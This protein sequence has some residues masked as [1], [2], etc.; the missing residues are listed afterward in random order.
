M[1]KIS[2]RRK[3][4]LESGAADYA[5]KRQDIV[6]AAAALFKDV[7]LG[8]ATM[9][10]VAKRA[11][12]DRASLYYYFKGKRD[13][14]REMVGAAT[15][16]NIEMAEAIAASSDGPEVKLRRLVIG[17][18]ESY[19]RH[20]PYLYVYLQEDMERLPQDNTVWSRRILDLNQRFN[21]AVTSIIRQGLETGVFQSKGSPKLIA[22]GV[23]GMCNW[24]HRWFRIDGPKSAGEIAEVFS[25]LVLSGL[26]SGHRG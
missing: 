16:D 1:S 22:A 23:L 11:G 20:Y 8:N 12:L 26:L 15:S 17:L 5:R 3:N 10:E 2:D 7:G 24:S 13:L 4:A 25:D 21:L 19:E 6:Q 9:D 18:F 14:F